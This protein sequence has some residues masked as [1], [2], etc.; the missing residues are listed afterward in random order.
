MAKSTYTAWMLIKAL[1]QGETLRLDMDRLRPESQAMIGKVNVKYMYVKMAENRSIELSGFGHGQWKP[2]EVLGA[3][4]RGPAG[5][6][7][8]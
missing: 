4:V 7:V 3:I 2:D 1:E 6:E 8:C 5:W